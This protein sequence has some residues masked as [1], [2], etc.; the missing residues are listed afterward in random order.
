VS[1]R[2]P[3]AWLRRVHGAVIGL[4]PRRF[5]DEYGPALR[6]VLRDMARERG[7]PAWQLWLTVLAD[8]P[9]SVVPEHMASWH[10]GES[11]RIR[12]LVD[13]PAVRVG[14][15]F[16]V[17]L[18]LLLAVYT[19]VNQAFVLNGTSYAV[20]NNGLTGAHLLC[21]VAAFVAARSAG[22]VRAGVVAGVGTALVGVA[23][24]MAALWI[25]TP[26]L[27]GNNF[28][29]P[30]MLEDFRRSGM[31]SMDAFI[32]DD[33]LGATLFG[34]LASLALGAVLGVAGGLLGRLM[35]GRRSPA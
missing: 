17:A 24:G 20:L 3:G 6:Q 1:G 14:A 33:A 18:G 35:A 31:Q 32:I 21:G 12:Q 15:G 26:I 10:G 11:M 34:T 28:H 27:W 16:G 9:G 7:V 25:A 19:V 13:D 2:E 5:R 29:N 22:T 23:I 30:G 8:V 4:Y